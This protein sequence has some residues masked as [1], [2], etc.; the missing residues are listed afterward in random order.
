MAKTKN[1][2]NEPQEDCV[3]SVLI[4]DEYNRGVKANLDGLALD[5]CPHSVEYSQESKD[6]KRYSW[7]VGWLDSNYSQ[8][9]TKPYNKN[10]KKI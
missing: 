1:E 8:S 2:K 9:T 4:E 10:N 7:C 5:D 3:L 6:G